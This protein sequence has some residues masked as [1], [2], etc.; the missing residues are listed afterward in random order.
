MTTD[1]KSLVG[2]YSLQIDQ[3]IARAFHEDGT[4]FTSAEYLALREPIQ[5]A[6]MNRK[7]RESMAA[8][9]PLCAT[10]TW[11]F[12]QK[13]E[14]PP[15]TDPCVYFLKSQSMPKMV[16]IGRT[17]NL[18]QRVMSLKFQIRHPETIAFVETSDTEQLELGL[19]TLFD[20]YHVKGEWFKDQPV[21]D[22]LRNYLDRGQA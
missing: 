13:H 18:R 2:H 15:K 5:R 7:W 20:A 3:S 8:V 6:Y 1:G 4:E 11:T 12:W 17:N 10:G 19:H 22:F 16:K 9:Y 14:F 21:I